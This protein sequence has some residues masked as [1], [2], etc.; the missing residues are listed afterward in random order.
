MLKVKEKIKTKSTKEAAAT[1]PSKP[2]TQ[3]DALADFLN[4]SPKTTLA[5]ERATVETKRPKSS[6]VTSPSDHAP[7]TASPKTST[8]ATPTV[9]K[10]PSFS[11]KDDMQKAY[12][13]LYNTGASLI[14]LISRENAALHQEVE[15]VRK[16]TTNEV[17]KLIHELKQSQQTPPGNVVKAVDA[18]REKFEKDHEALYA[19][20][21]DWKTDVSG[22]IDAL[23]KLKTPCALT[24]VDM[25][26]TMRK[27]YTSF[28]E[29]QKLIDSQ[30][31]IPATKED[32]TPLH[33][34]YEDLNQRITKLETLLVQLKQDNE[35]T[36]GNITRMFETIQQDLNRQYSTSSVSSST[37]SSRRREKD[38]L[39]ASSCYFLPS[40]QKKE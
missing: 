24:K 4:P 9:E 23:L 21:K 37:N 34:K 13:K 19:H 11:H 5:K 29:S 7:D 16:D 31:P 6:K 10:S 14:G 26:T 39:K 20:L 17:S 15:A 25:I 32:L 18:M 28:R 27:E 8:A 36:M 2:T 1:K 40:L 12:D 33:E 35:T 38:I 30:R 22:R 3:K